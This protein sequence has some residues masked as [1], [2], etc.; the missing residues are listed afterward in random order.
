M[1][2]VFGV[3]GI[4]V[5]IFYDNYIGGLIFIVGIVTSVCVYLKE[6]RGW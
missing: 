3:A 1:F 4:I 5:A 6:N 2:A